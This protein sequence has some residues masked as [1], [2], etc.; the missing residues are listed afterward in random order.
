MLH[1]YGETFHSKSM[2]KFSTRTTFSGSPR[3]KKFVNTNARV[4]GFFNSQNLQFLLPGK[5]CGESKL[6]V[7][8]L[9]TVMGYVALLLHECSGKWCSGKC[10]C[11][12]CTWQSLC[13]TARFMKLYAAVVLS[14][15]NNWTVC[16]YVCVWIHEL[17]NKLQSLNTPPAQTQIMYEYLSPTSCLIIQTDNLP[18]SRTTRCLA[19][20]ITCYH[21]PIIH[22]CVSLH[23]SAVSQFVYRSPSLWCECVC[24]CLRLP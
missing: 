22:M 11:F 19:W 1:L 3:N 12:I 8:G 9:Q 7:T 23:S 16:T 24:V 15:I 13:V 10:A 14:V 4:N 6:W 5:F 20:L 21:D 2:R 18:M 17:Q